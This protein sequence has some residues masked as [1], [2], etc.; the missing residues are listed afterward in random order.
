M[1]TKRP[2]GLIISKKYL[3]EFLDLLEI[4]VNHL[5]HCT[6]AM[7]KLTK[8]E[9]ECLSFAKKLIDGNTK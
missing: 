4:G 7:K 2:S 8:K 9:L 3:P 5:E 6:S 1:K